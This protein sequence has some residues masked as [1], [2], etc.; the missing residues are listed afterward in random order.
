MATDTVPSNWTPRPKGFAPWRP[1]PKTLVLMDQVQ[2][3]LNEY[4]QHLPLTLRQIFYRLVGQYDFPKNEPAYKQLGE[5]LVRARR[6]GMIPF[7]SIRD[8]GGVGQGGEGYDSFAEWLEG[9][10]AAA[11][12]YARNLRAGQPVAIELWCEASGMVPQLA[13]VASKFDITTYSAQLGFASITLTRQIAHRAL[14][15]DRPTVLLH[16]GDFDP[17][18]YSIY[19]AIA[20]DAGLFVEQLRDQ[21]DGE[22][23]A[24]IDPVRVA[25]TA[26][27]VSEYDLPTA[28]PKATDSRSRNWDGDTCQLE[29]MAPDDISRI[30]KDTIESY[31]DRDELD[32]V[33]AE[34]AD[35]RERAQ[36]MIGRMLHDA[37]PDT[38]ESTDPADNP[39]AW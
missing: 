30:V 20:A 39:Y 31:I 33:K 2:A 27:Q 8:D 25:L 16:V 11:D 29:A 7:G 6:S 19:E 32:K 5:H 9:E 3:V 28:P 13:R 18:G 37:D 26:E 4:R 12:S 23:N 21:G 36:R 22:E 34:Q 10:R 15:Q 35:E 14:R 24:R 38:Y 17:S 1:H